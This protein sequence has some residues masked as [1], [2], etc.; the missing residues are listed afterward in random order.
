VEKRQMIFPRFTLTKRPGISWNGLG[1]R[2]TDRK[3]PRSNGKNDG[4]L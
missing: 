4:D 3:P 2:K 1:H